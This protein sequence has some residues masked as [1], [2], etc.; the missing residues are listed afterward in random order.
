MLIPSISRVGSRTLYAG[1]SAPAT[2]ASRP[3]SGA[4]TQAAAEPAQADPSDDG[5]ADDASVSATQEGMT[6]AGAQA[7]YASN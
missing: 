7:A 5:E 4:S 3:P 2:R 6:L 1:R